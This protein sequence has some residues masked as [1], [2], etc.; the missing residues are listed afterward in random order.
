MVLFFSVCSF[1]AW[2]FAKE[3]RMR[4]VS[5][6]A[7]AIALGAAIS[8]HYNAVLIVIPILIGEL[9]WTVRRRAIDAPVLIAICASG[10]PILFLLPHIHAISAY[11]KNNWSHSTFSALTEI[12]FALF[13]KFLVL[14]M[15][16]GAVFGFWSS[17]SRERLR[18]IHAEFGALPPHEIAAA[19]GYLILPFALFVLSLYTKAL[20]Y[21]YVIATVIGLALFVPFVLWMFRSLLSKAAAFFCALLVLNLLYTGLSR[22]R[23]PDEATWGTFES[24][25]ELFSPAT[26]EIYRS[27]QALVLGDGPFLLVTKYG[28]AGLR[29][30]SFY[31]L[32]KLHQTNTSPFIF[33]GLQ[34]VVHGPFH[35]PNVTEFEQTHRSF[36]MYAPDLWVLDQLF[37]EGDQVR[38]LADLPHGFLYEVTIKH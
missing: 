38:I 28:D 18:G 3:E 16:A 10:T 37:A 22:V 5:V 14:I 32:S 34:K 1:L 27:N 8:V 17:I 30:R 31:P 35:L 25:S 2:Q 11:S 33:A 15:F 36:L 20:H 4:V 23:S 26:K 12:Y 13:A 19:G 29:E 24:Y 21:R 7:I 6:P 9:A